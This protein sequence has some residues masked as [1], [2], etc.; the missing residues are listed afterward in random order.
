[1]LERLIV[2]LVMTLAIECAVSFAMGVRGED[3]YESIILIN[4]ITN[5]IVV[6]LTSLIL[7]WTQQ[8]EIA[9]TVLAVLEIAVAGVEGA[10]FQYRLTGVKQNPY[11]FSICLN[12]ASLAGG[13]LL[14]AIF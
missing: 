10:W 3:S 2:S 11:L 5:P 4:C 12:T 14:N 9:Y 7:L 8:T 1:M 6:G 13:L